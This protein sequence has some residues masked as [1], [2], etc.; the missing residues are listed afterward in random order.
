MTH[1]PLTHRRQPAEGDSSFLL[2]DTVYSALHA[3]EMWELFRGSLSDPSS[4]FEQASSGYTIPSPSHLHALVSRSSFQGASPLA[5]PRGR[6]ASSSLIPSFVFPSRFPESFP[7]SLSDYAGILPASSRDE[8]QKP[9][10]VRSL[11]LGMEVALLSERVSRLPDGGLDP[12]SDL[13]WLCL[14]QAYGLYQQDTVAFLNR[15]LMVSQDRLAR[16]LDFFQNYPSNPSCCRSFVGLHQRTS[17]ASSG[18]PFGASEA[19]ESRVPTQQPLPPLHIHREG[20]FVC[21]EVPA[22][23]GASGAF[24]VGEEGRAVDSTRRTVDGATHCLEDE[25]ETHQTNLTL[26]MLEE[27]PREAAPSVCSSGI[28][29]SSVSSPCRS[30][31]SSP[32]CSF[33]SSRASCLPSEQDSHEEPLESPLPSLSEPVPGM[34]TSGE[35]KKAGSFQAT[36]SDIAALL[37][38]TGKERM[39]RR[40]RDSEKPHD[41]RPRDLLSCSASLGGSTR[42]A[43]SQSGSVGSSLECLSESLASIDAAKTGERRWLHHAFHFNGSKAE[44]AVEFDTEDEGPLTDKASAAEEEVP[45]PRVRRA[46]ATA[47]IQIFRGD[48]CEEDADLAPSAC[49]QIAEDRHLGRSTT[50]SGTSDDENDEGQADDVLPCANPESAAKRELS[51][52]VCGSRG[53]EGTDVDRNTSDPQHL[54]SASS[55]SPVSG[56]QRK[57]LSSRPEDSRQSQR[58]HKR[59]RRRLRRARSC[60]GLV[61]CRGLRGVRHSS[62]ALPDQLRR[63]SVDLVLV[64]AAWRRR[65]AT[66]CSL[67][68]REFPTAFSDAFARPLTKE[69]FS[70]NAGPSSCSDFC[71][72]PSF[73]HR[74][75]SQPLSPPISPSPSDPVCEKEDS[76][77]RY[78][79]ESTECLPSSRESPSAHA[80]PPSVSP[81]SP[82]RARHSQLKDFAL[83]LQ[84]QMRENTLRLQI[85]QRQQRVLV[86]HHETA[87]RRQQA[88]L[89]RLHE[90]Q[91]YADTP[92]LYRNSRAS[93]AP[94]CSSNMNIGQ[95]SP[96]SGVGSVP[97]EHLPE[98]GPEGEGRGHGVIGSASGSMERISFPPTCEALRVANGNLHATGHLRQVAASQ[99]QADMR[100]RSGGMLL[101]SFNPIGGMGEAARNGEIPNRG[102]HLPFTMTVSSSGYPHQINSGQASSRFERAGTDP[103][104]PAYSFAT[105]SNLSDQQARQRSS[106]VLYSG[107]PALS[108]S[109]PSPSPLV[110]NGSFY[111]AR[112]PLSPAMIA[113]SVSGRNASCTSP[114][115]STVGQE[116]A[117]H[118]PFGPGTPAPELGLSRHQLDDSVAASAASLP[119]WRESMRRGEEAETHE[120]AHTFRTSSGIIGVSSRPLSSISA[121]SGTSTETAAFEI[122]PVGTQPSLPTRGSSWV[123]FRYRWS[124]SPAFD[125]SATPGVSQMF[126]PAQERE[127]HRQQSF[128]ETRDRSV[129]SPPCGPIDMRNYFYRPNRGP[130]PQH[131]WRRTENCGRGEGFPGYLCLGETPYGDEGPRGDSHALQDGSTA[132]GYS[133]PHVA[134]QR[135]MQSGPS[136]PV[137]GSASAQRNE[138]G[139]SGSPSSV[140]AAQPPLSRTTSAEMR[141]PN[142]VYA[143]NPSTG[144]RYMQMRQAGEAQPRYAPCG[145]PGA[146]S[147]YEHHVLLQQQR[148]QQELLQ[149]QLMKS[150][151]HIQGLRALMGRLLVVMEHLESRDALSN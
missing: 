41:S 102:R 8:G 13:T 133:F 32:I 4:T 64:P 115:V 80:I 40:K 128:P 74:F 86:E 94:Q 14:L 78:T 6:P 110:A 123:P 77:Q 131:E 33:S 122:H 151:E 116:E 103:P 105:F 79:Q 31:D 18:P 42:A 58:A 46:L 113:A 65:A 140:T 55:P 98:A 85:L 135:R 146:P 54:M 23:R 44:R 60:P 106:G 87:R 111:Q 52:S 119:L 62:S 96:F 82:G 92:S 138:R 36:P 150:E 24:S 9:L 16:I 56:F 99:H 141:A 2:P 21:G 66:H 71:D 107:S 12:A 3:G 26:S 20:S 108:P 143:F 48:T 95:E 89:Q 76:G 90:A 139:I 148:Q 73:S 72:S 39:R 88:T 101:L 104:S 81:V 30:A 10:C 121:A 124:P 63:H 5:D 11:V 19:P 126:L 112:G 91:Q 28:P 93:G 127:G 97:R 70:L 50:E 15:L 37:S 57:C 120:A 47:T 22:S 137:G 59:S 49:T 75:P 29:E 125:L 27:P 51:L 45:R 43:A 17:P 61:F 100:E 109:A 130:A 132:C 1:Q 145:Q 35:G 25:K 118:F 34:L 147:R 136:I 38:S 129:S 7:L 149:R 68:C 67:S 53:E 142:H 134:G 117:A 69:S 84:L 83:A 114:G 144:G